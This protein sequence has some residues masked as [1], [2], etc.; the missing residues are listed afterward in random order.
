[1]ANRKQEL[2]DFFNAIKNGNIEPD[3][4]SSKIALITHNYKV[5]ELITLQKD[6]DIYFQNEQRI[7]EAGIIGREPYQFKNTDLDPDRNIFNYCHIFMSLLKTLIARHSNT[8]KIIYE[9]ILPPQLH[10]P[11]ENSKD[12][13]K[14]GAI[15]NPLE[16]G[17]IFVKDNWKTYI[18]ALHK[19]ENPVIDKEYNF[20]GLPR[21]DKGVICSWIKDLQTKGF[22]NK[23]YN[24][25][26]LVTVLNNEIKGLNLGKDGKT[27]DNSSTVYDTK[28]KENLIKLTN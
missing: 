28:Y 2:E 13:N 23:K 3:E 26:Q 7:R 6:F 20:I 11:T 18:D 24:R 4:Y 17:D 5:A 16:F 14:V 8:S 9:S 19:V 27:F 22:I 1:M 15:E 12:K 21:K 25:Q 10:Q